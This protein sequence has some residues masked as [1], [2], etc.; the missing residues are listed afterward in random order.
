LEFVIGVLSSLVAG[1]ILVL[2]TGVLSVKGRRVLTATLGSLL[3]IDIEYVFRDKDDAVTD[4]VEEM[5]RASFI[6]L[7]TSRGSELQREPFSSALAA[8]NVRI[9]LPNPNYT[10]CGADWTTQ[11]EQE[12]VK[13]D[14]TYGNNLLH[15]QIN[16]VIK[17]LAQSSGKTRP[18][19]S[20]I[21]RLTSVAF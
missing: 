13:F 21:I 15:S 6:C 8:G 19:L 17:F 10:E 18:S 1:V 20:S 3:N 14:E 7:L 11:R 16:T 9:L 4:Y 2:G 5:K 12:M